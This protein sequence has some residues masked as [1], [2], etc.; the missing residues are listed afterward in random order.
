MSRRKGLSLEE[1]RS[2]MLE[3]FYEKKDFFMMKELEKIA[4][5][6]KG[7]IAQSV[8]DVVQ[9]LV[10][11]NMVDTEKIGT[12]VYF[13]AFP[14]KASIQLNKRVS[15][16]EEELKTAQ[17]KLIDLKAKTEVATLQR[18]ENDERCEALSTLEVEKQRNAALLAE[19]KQYADS[20]PETLRVLEVE[21]ITALEAA[22]RW[23]DNIF[24]IKSWCKNK[25][26]IEDDVINK[27]FGIPED[28]D[29]V[30][31]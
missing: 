23:T 21:T 26:F 31:I 30:A 25:F 5:K 11:D 14:S 20:D 3:L 1:K 10:D 22:N 13:W 7:I 4:P 27:Q 12:C 16:L 9:S 28:L 15:K 6:E 18:S 8:K 2:K 17:E 24:T 29:Y 19:L